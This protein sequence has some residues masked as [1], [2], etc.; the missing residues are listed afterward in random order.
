MQPGQYIGRFEVQRTLGQGGIATVYQVRHP[1]LDTLHALK[2][3]TINQRGLSRR[4]LQEGKIQAKLRHPNVVAVTDVVEHGDAIGLLM[5]YVEGYSLEDCLNGGRMALDEALATFKQ[6]LAGVGAAHAAG[7][8]HRD[9]KPA[10]ILLTTRGEDVVAKVL[11]FGI[12]KV[13][14]DGQTRGAT[15][16]GTTMGTPGYMAPEQIT[17][18]TDTDHRADVFAL[19]AILYEMIT[20][21]RAFHGDDMLAIL[22]AT[23]EGDYPRIQDRMPGI[24]AHVCHAVDHALQVDRDRRT[25]DCATMARELY[26]DDR[27]VAR[28]AS[29]G[30]GP[31]EAIRPTASA[32]LPTLAPPSDEDRRN[33]TLVSALGTIARRDPH[34]FDDEAPTEPPHP[35]PLANLAADVDRAAAPPTAAPVPDRITWAG[36]VDDTAQGRDDDPT[37]LEIQL[38]R[39]QPQTTLS[40]YLDSMRDEEVRPEDPSHIAEGVSAEDA[41]REVGD[42]IGSMLSATAWALGRALK[43]G[44]LPLLILMGF[45][46]WYGHQAGALLT[47]LDS[48]RTSAANNLSGAMDGV[49]AQV[50]RLVAAGGDA[51]LLYAMRKRYEEAPDLEA[52]VVAAQNL[53]AVMVEQMAQL[54]PA[55]GDSEREMRH[56]VQ[57][58]ITAI[59]SEASRYEQVSESYAEVEQSLGGRAAKAGS[60]FR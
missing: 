9:L 33:R 48:Q 38:D 18:A 30:L 25:P 44:A 21:D 3:L 45:L 57:K 23:A 6:I 59:Q 10:N 11:D 22:N 32:P 12:A 52:K 46:A 53:T 13:I 14:E 4:L 51:K 43:H 1:Q 47:D 27:F 35:S 37:D 50:P 17:D 31:F 15:R 20:G 26:G 2:M 42:L 36:L 34:P 19:G 8:T 16:A 49:V 7:V 56:E 39:K 60:L 5:E 29:K 28:P 55:H 40:R 24:P 54:P 58:A 41:K